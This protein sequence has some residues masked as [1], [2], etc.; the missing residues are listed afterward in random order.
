VRAPRFRGESWKE[1]DDR[2]QPHFGLLDL[3]VAHVRVG[4]HTSEPCALRIHDRESGADALFVQ[5]ASDFAEGLVAISLQADLSDDPQRAPGVSE[6]GI[7]PSQVPVGVPIVK[8]RLGAKHRGLDL[9]HRRRGR[10]GDQACR[11]LRSLLLDSGDGSA[12]G[13]QNEFRRWLS[14]IPDGEE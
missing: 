8:P 6:L 7:S 12:H 14:R 3:E 13:Q 2:A 5:I 10:D 4:L 11:E 9:S 1:A